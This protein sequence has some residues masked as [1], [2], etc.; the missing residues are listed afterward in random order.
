M[1]MN[2]SFLMVNARKPIDASA[3]PRTSESTITDKLYVTTLFF[4]KAKIPK[5]LN[6]HIAIPIEK[7]PPNNKN[8]L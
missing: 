8:F 2:D 7:L 1:L 3:T 6:V 4:S 5:K